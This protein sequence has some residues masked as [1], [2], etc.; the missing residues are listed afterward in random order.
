[1]NNKGFSTILM[2]LAVGV[3]GLAVVFSLSSLSISSNRIVASYYYSK[4]ATY[5]AEA[6]ANQGYLATRNNLNFFGIQNFT[7][8][9]ITC[10]FNVLYLGNN[11]RQVDA[12]ATVRGHT[13]KIRA[14]YLIERSKLVL[15]SWQLVTDF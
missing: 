15:Q 7:V 4:R 11:M 5:L 1:M 9:N 3:G 14:V 8:D 2:V 6:C 12:W 13:K 10:T